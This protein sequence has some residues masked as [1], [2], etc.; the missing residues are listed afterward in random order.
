MITRIHQSAPKRLY[1]KEHREDREISPEQMAGRLGIERES[2][3]RIERNPHKVK[4]ERQVQWA[5]AL[6]IEPEEL[7]LPPGI[8]SV[9]GL[10]AKVPE[11]Q[12]DLAR[13]MAA[14][15]VRRLLPKTG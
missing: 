13:D 9:D 6:G 12:R 11:E 2:V 10:M 1:L 3:H 8:P 14:D 15:I 5:H 4:F 7:W